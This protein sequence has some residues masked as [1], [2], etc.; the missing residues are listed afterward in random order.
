MRV[1]PSRSPAAPGTANHQTRD[2]GGQSAQ[3]R[4]A[5]C[6]GARVSL[7]SHTNSL[8]ASSERHDQ[9]VAANSWHLVRE[10]QRATR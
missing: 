10:R 3:R 7:H 4:G 1:R 5:V 9:S 6:F 8:T 2:S